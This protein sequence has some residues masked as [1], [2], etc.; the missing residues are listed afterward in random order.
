MNKPITQNKTHFTV[1]TL[2]S[3]PFH[4]A[5]TGRERWA[6]E[7]LISAGPNGCTAIEHPGPRWAAYVRDLRVMGVQINTVR[8]SHGGP[9]ADYHARY[10]LAS[11]VVRLMGAAA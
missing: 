3:R 5:V 1:Q 7:T 10:I 9:F 11:L 4:I 6:L 8:E 2:S